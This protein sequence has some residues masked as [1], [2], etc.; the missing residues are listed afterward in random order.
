MCFVIMNWVKLTFTFERSD[1]KILRSRT[2]NFSQ[3]YKF[4]SVNVILLSPSI[5]KCFECYKL[6]VINS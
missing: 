1:E 2:E 4:L 3:T 6:P 5:P